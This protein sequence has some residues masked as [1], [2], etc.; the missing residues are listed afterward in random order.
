M[1]SQKM[2]GFYISIGARH[3]AYAGSLGKILLSGLSEEKFEEY[4]ASV[5][6]KVHTAETLTKPASLRREIAEVKRLGYA[7]NRGEFN[8][9]IVGVAVPVH[10]KDGAVAGAVNVNWISVQPIK[11]AEIKRCLGPLHQAA[12]QIEVRLSSGPVPHGWMPR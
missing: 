4:L 2:L 5:P 9:G 3:P 6:L 8:A 1:F 12:K 10:N 7:L 11:P